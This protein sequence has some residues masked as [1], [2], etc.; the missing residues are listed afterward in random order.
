[1]KKITI[2]LVV[3][4]LAVAVFTFV[5][6]WGERSMALEQENVRQAPSATPATGPPEFGEKFAE[7]SAVDTATA[8]AGDRNEHPA[9]LPDGE[10]SVVVVDG[11]S[12]ERASDV[13]V[14]A[15]VAYAGH[16]TWH[17]ARTD[18]SGAA[19]F[20][21][22]QTVT[23]CCVHVPPVPTRV[24]V[25]EW[26]QEAL[27]P[28]EKR[29]VTV[30]LRA[31]YTLTGHVVDAVGQGLPDAEVL[32]WC[33]MYKK[34][35]LPHR[36][37]VTAADG[38][39]LLEHLGPR[40]V[41]VAR[42]EGLACVEGLRGELKADTQ[43]PGL[44]I[45]MGPARTLR[46]T[47]LSPDRHPIADADVSV[48]NGLNSTS[49]LDATPTPGVSRFKGGDAVTTSGADGRFLLEGLPAVN[50]LLHVKAAPFLTYSQ[51]HPV[52]GPPVEVV[53]DPGLTLVGRVVDAAAKPAKGARVR[54]GTSTMV[55]DED[56][57]FEVSGM[58]DRG[59]PPPYLYVLHDGHAVEL[60]QPVR[61]GPGRGEFLKIQ[62]KPERVL[63]GRVVDDEGSGVEGVEVWIEGDREFDPGFTHARR[64]TWEWRA[65]IDTAT[66]DATGA[67][68]FA[69]L[70]DGGFL[71]HAV[72]PEDGR[73]TIDRRT[74]AGDE[75]V[76][77]V[78]NRAAYRKVVLAGTVRD[79]ATNEPVKAFTITP[80]VNGKGQH[81]HKLEDVEGRFEVAG[82][83][84]GE[85][86]ILFKAPRYASYRIPSREYSIGEHEL[87]VWLKLARTL[88]LRV[89]DEDGKPHSNG[90]VR[91]LDADGQ[92]LSFEL[93][94]IPRTSASLQ[95]APLV[96]PGLPEGL[97]T[98]RVSLGHV[99]KSLAVDLHLVGDEEVEFVIPRKRFAY[100]SVTVLLIEGD[101]TEAEVR[102]AWD[103]ALTK[104]DFTWL[105]NRVN[106]GDLSLPE[107]PLLVEATQYGQ[108]VAQL[109]IEPLA[110]GSFSTETCTLPEGE[111]SIEVQGV[112]IQK[113]VMHFEVIAGEKFQHLLLLLRSE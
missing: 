22:A 97:V 9:P 86:A 91:V 24:E 80:F 19:R 83:K 112:G 4:L 28:G 69:N 90:R 57:R 53:L 23:V 15:Q 44:E 55:C 16:R 109:K 99:E 51:Y 72:S 39:F 42:K 17:E 93:A 106:A 77:L 100:V 81:H 52:G 76:E 40:F 34:G 95:G 58:I 94:G 87:D 71:V 36:T 103:E 84:A 12:G 32:A 38:S 26:M 48:T 92:E 66:T 75:N 78:L 107:Q 54:S 10:L 31:G 6:T 8:G 14:R 113:A 30:T 1:M 73:S 27:E 63:A 20:S 102:R 35:D 25:E 43:L 96:L 3:V 79:A 88:R 13:L 101:L 59:D 98:V 29:E 60:V 67:F 46:G 5:R 74:S 37:T 62:L 104:N 47:V 11:A 70:Y 108:H 65:G 7:R 56:G 64:S 41:A 82:L 18:P 2:A 68:R 61:P 33:G 110:G 89:V 85:I 111:V 21:F 49:T 50:A 105:M 45:R